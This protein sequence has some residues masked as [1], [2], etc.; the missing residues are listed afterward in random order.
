M[1]L[2]R[3]ATLPSAEFVSQ[4]ELLLHVNV[5]LKM[6]QVSCKICQCV[7]WQP[8]LRC[9][10]PSLDD[11]RREP[12]QSSLSHTSKAAGC[13]FGS[14]GSDLGVYQYLPSSPLCSFSPFRSGSFFG[15][16][17]LHDSTQVFL[18]PVVAFLTSLAAF[19]TCNIFSSWLSTDSYMILLKKFSLV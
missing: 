19:V 6:L 10:H 14:A 3:T 7:V 12:S 16:P 17:L 8:C 13:E 15:L 5:S 9:L 1:P 18:F 11:S 2:W 4:W